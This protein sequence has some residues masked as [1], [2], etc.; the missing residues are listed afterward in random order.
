MSGLS[1]VMAVFGFIDHAVVADPGLTPKVSAL[2]P[3]Y[4]EGAAGWYQ[5][6]SDWIPAALRL[7]DRSKKPKATDG[8][9][10]GT[11]A[12]SDLVASDMKA[13]LIAFSTLSDDD[14]AQDDLVARRLLALAVLGRMWPSMDQAHSQLARQLG[15]ADVG[16]DLLVQAL[17]PLT[18]AR[19]KDK[20]GRLLSLLVGGQRPGESWGSLLDRAANAGLIPPATASLQCSPASWIVKQTPV[21]PAIAFKTH[22]RIV[23]M[24][25]SEFGDL[26]DP[27]KWTNFSPPWCAMTPGKASDGHDVYLEVLSAACPTVLPFRLSTPLQFTD[28]ALPD[29]TGQSLQYRLTP[30][31]S[32]QGGDGLVTVDEGSIAVREWQGAIHLITTKRIQ[33]RVFDKMPPLEAAMIA[34]FV[35]TLGYSSLAEYFVNRVTRRKRIQVADDPES[36]RIPARRRSGPS[37]SDQLGEVV[38]RDVAECV[39]GIESTLGKVK[40]RSYGTAEYAD[41]LR[42]FV[43]H[44]ARYGSD[45]LDIASQCLSDDGSTKQGIFTSGRG[46][47]VSEPLAMPPSAGSATQP[48]GTPVLECSDLQPGLMQSGPDTIAAKIVRCEPNRNRTHDDYRIVIEETSL[49]FQPGGTYTGTVKVRTDPNA[50]ETESGAWIVIP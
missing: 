50:P 16:A 41:D 27:T 25:M 14:L 7:A 12:Q 46:R 9:D 20:A 4:N 1:D 8:P 18:M 22:K 23:G 28:V 49:Q 39:E 43:K 37:S 33:F 13:A 31:W 17:Q 36:S 35:W 47:Y 48:P 24:T 10:L 6:V 5:G 11:E 19:D 30:D 2:L 40:K 26:L 44:V 15:G 32:K 45:L 29:G 3:A 42:K 38:K 21:G 34:Q